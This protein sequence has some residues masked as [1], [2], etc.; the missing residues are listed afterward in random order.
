M[1]IFYALCFSLPLHRGRERHLT[2]MRKETQQCGWRCLLFSWWWLLSSWWGVFH[3]LET[4]LGT[5]HALFHLIE[6]TTVCDRVVRSLPHLDTRKLVLKK[7]NWLAQL[8]TAGRN[9]P[10]DWFHLA[11]LHLP[12]SSAA[13]TQQVC[14]HA[15]PRKIVLSNP[16][17]LLCIRAVLVHSPV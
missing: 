15:R 1:R 13:L 17:K 16:I 9:K 5:S 6:P 12:C 8:P 14:A 3:D 10:W 2:F 11:L 4:V 7:V